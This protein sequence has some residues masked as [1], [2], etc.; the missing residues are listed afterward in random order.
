MCVS[1]VYKVI[2]G[3]WLP[4]GC[5]GCPDCKRKRIDAWVFRMLQEEKRS[6]SAHFITLT[7]DSAHVPISTNGY[8]TLTKG[9]SNCFTRFMKRLR[10][11]CPHDQIKYYAC[12]EYGENR[13]RPHWHAIVFN[14]SDENA[15]KQAWSLDG[16]LI[17][18]VD[19]GTVTSKSIAYTCG[20]INKRKF[21]TKHSRD[22]RVPEFSV[23]S[24]GLGENF[25][26]PAISRYYQSDLSRMYLTKEGGDRIAMPRYY[27][28]RILDEDQRAFQGSIVE[29]A[30]GQKNSDDYARYLELYPN[31]ELSYHDYIQRNREAVVHSFYSQSKKRNYD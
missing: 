17:G 20:Y 6:T 22:D 29:L 15:Y 23:M 13:S 24:K 9:P 16:C 3:R 8:M 12:G 25:V 11:L 30:I 26:T 14:V 18:R 7:Y 4:L 5:G 28:N 10:K 19:V 27:R 31:N 1:P 2:N 21:A